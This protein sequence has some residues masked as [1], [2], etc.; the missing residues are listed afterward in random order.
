MKDRVGVH[1]VSEIDDVEAQPDLAAIF[2]RYRDRQWLFVTPGGN[3]GDHLIYA[4]A[5]KLARSSGLKWS[6][7]DFAGF[8]AMTVPPES[9]IYLH[10][11]GGFNSWGSGRP[12]D[13]LARAASV[14]GAVVVQGPQTCEVGNPDVGARF[15]RLMD[16]ARCA[17]VFA[18]ARERTSWEYMREHMPGVVALGLAQ[19]TALHLEP[20]DVLSMAR[21]KERPRGRYDLLI[22]RRDDETPGAVLPSETYELSLDPAMYADSF[23]HWMRIHL[24]ARSIVTNRL[25]SAILGSIAGI[26]VTLLPGSYHKNRSIW[27]FSLRERGVAWAD[28]APPGGGRGFDLPSL[29]PPFLRRSWKVQRLAMRLKGM[30]GS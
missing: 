8:Q 24:Y 16:E 28:S 6:D 9:C 25:H 22:S 3:W 20:A 23:A 7:V 5:E 13:M 14:P 19:D 15:S 11:G 12:F 27:E 21:L 1:P 10:G 18:F 26:P 2:A 30:P 17:S 4:G 29:C